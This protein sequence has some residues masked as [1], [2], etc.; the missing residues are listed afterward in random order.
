VKN[1]EVLKSKFILYD[2]CFEKMVSYF[3]Q[4]MAQ[5]AHVDGAEVDVLSKIQEGLKDNFMA[6]ARAAVEQRP[7]Q[8]V[9]ENS[10]N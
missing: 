8:I 1:V 3:K 5:K 4:A 6:L 7:Q 9:V 10:W 2:M